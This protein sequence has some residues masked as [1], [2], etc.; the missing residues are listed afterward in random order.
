MYNSSNSHVVGL[1]NSFRDATK[2]HLLDPY[3]ILVDLFV[4]GKVSRVCFVNTI[5]E[6]NYS[7]C[8]SIISGNTALWSAL[9]NPNHRF[10][11]FRW[12]FFLSEAEQTLLKKENKAFAH[13]SENE[14]YTPILV[15]HSSFAKTYK[16][17]VPNLRK[18]EAMRT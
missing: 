12:Q 17:I 1:L 9:R 18:A 4:F 13:L 8:F 3:Y 5:C 11:N 7:S 16:Q 10:A 2:H 15:A 14:D 6:E